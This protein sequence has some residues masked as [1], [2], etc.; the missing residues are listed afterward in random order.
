[1]KDRKVAYIITDNNV[2][3]N[4]EGETHIVKRSDA[5]ADRLIKAVK[6]GKLQEIPSL[7]SAAKRI[8]T[9]SKGAFLVKDG[10]VEINGVPSPQVLSDKIVRFSDDGLPFQPL[11]K[12]AENL[13]KNP[14]YRSVN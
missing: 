11:L 8:E 3:V 9:F 1:M 5:L 7:V 2:T 6:E 10:R 14:S 12:F 13:Q 4:Y